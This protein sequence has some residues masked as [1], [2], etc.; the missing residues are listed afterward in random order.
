MNNPGGVLMQAFSNPQ[1]FM[2]HV[3]NNSELMKNPIAKNTIE[4]MKNGDRK[5]TE[6]IARNLLK[7]RGINPDDALRQVKSMFGM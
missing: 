6:E 5:G 1:A 2:N 7:E 3:M 4:M